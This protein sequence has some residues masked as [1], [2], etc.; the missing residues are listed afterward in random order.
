MDTGDR[1]RAASSNGWAIFSATMI[2]MVGAINLIQGFVAMFVPDYYLSASGDLLFFNFQIWGLGLGIW[3][4]VLLATGFSLMSGRMWA[5]V[6][7]V[8]L[9]ALNAIAQLGFLPAFPLWTM[10][11]IAID[12]LVIY[13]LTAGW[14]SVDERASYR[15]GHADATG[16]VDTRSDATGH[17]DV[18]SDSAGSD[19]TRSEPAYSDAT[20]S[21]AARSESAYSDAA[22]RG[23]PES[24]GTHASRGSSPASAAE[25]EPHGVPE[26]PTRGAHEA[27]P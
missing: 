27:T 9:A 1:S 2:L 21:D 23:E 19:A 4:I 10:V 14:P 24:R 15:S 6:L 12:V 5:R 20:R 25:P 8:V 3:G 26:R 11:V 13:G 17:A 18:R 22:V 7:G 16:H